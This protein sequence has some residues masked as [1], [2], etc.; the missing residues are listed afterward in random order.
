MPHTEVVFQVRPKIC[1]KLSPHCWSK[2]VNW[3]RHIPSRFCADRNCFFFYWRSSYRG[4]ILKWEGEFMT[5]SNWFGYGPLKQWRNSSFWGHFH[6]SLFSWVL[7]SQNYVNEMK[8]YPSSR[9][10]LADLLEWQNMQSQLGTRRS[11]HGWRA[12]KMI[13]TFELQTN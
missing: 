13:E 10:C 8:L 7:C 6:I 5:G 1:L 11:Y 12:L 3:T 2:I 4:E 9:I